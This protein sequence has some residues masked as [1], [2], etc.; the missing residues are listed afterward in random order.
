M[1]KKPRSY[2]VSRARLRIFD[3]LCSHLNSA[4]C[5]PETDSSCMSCHISEVYYLI[6][7]KIKKIDVVDCYENKLICRRV[8]ISIF[9]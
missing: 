6:K 1:K 5:V 9:F 8:E 3:N 7:K 4:I 2:F